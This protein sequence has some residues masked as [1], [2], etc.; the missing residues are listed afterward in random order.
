MRPAQNAVF[1]PAEARSA[2]PDDRRAPMGRLVALDLRG[3]AWAR[4]LPHPRPAD[5][6]LVALSRA[7]DHSA[8]W[9]VLGVAGAAVD[10]RQRRAWMDATARIAAVELAVRATKR[11]ARRPRPVIGGLA[12]LAAAPS[13]L[14][15]P[16][17]HTAAALAAVTAFDGLLPRGLLRAVAVTTAFSRLYLGLHYPSDVIAG[18]LL[19]RALAQVRRRRARVTGSTAGKILRGSESNSGRLSRP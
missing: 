11:V 13:P 16:S 3:V 2:K 1:V 18:G 9:F 19:G 5:T 6:V 14:S 15:F 12:P 17:S 4:A 8:A 7:T 10:H